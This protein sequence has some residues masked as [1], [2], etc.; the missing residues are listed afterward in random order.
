[1]AESPGPYDQLWDAYQE[2]GRL[3]NHPDLADAVLQIL[4]PAARSV[5]R[6]MGYRP[7][8][9]D[10]V[11]AGAVGLLEA[12]QRFDPCRGVQ[13][14]TF[15]SWRI[16]GA[17]YDDQRE[18]R[19][20]K[21]AVRVKAQRAYAAAEELRQSLGRQPDDQELADAL[22]LSP[23]Q[24]AEIRPFIRYPRPLSLSAGDNAEADAP[25][26]IP[27]EDPRE[28]PMRLILAAEARTRLLDALKS[29]PD[30]QRY[31]LLLYYFEQ[32][33]LA[34]IGTVLGLSE[35]RIHQIRAKALKHMVQRLGPDG[36]ELL[37]AMGK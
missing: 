36:P 18:A 12:L 28:D 22:D 35:P 8:L 27:L 2:T 34:Q 15:A 24:L 3:S 23:A 29:L 30:Q 17:M 21:G 19:W 31:T 13:L 33:T 11:S 32:L 10:L 5:R 37:D 6:A 26:A 4:L 20:A 14:S 25:A 7:D 9:G 16:V 1:V